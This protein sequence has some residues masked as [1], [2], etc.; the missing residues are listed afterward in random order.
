M[1]QFV[2]GFCNTNNGGKEW[3]DL[4]ADD[5]VLGYSASTPLELNKIL[6]LD[7]SLILDWYTD[8]RL[9][10]NVKKTKIMFAGSKTMLSKFEDFNISREGGQIDFVSSFIY[11]GVI[12]DQKWNWNIHVTSLLRKLGRWLSVLNRILRIL[13]KRTRLAYFN[14]LVFPHL[15]YADTV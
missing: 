4:V 13:D 9:T 6:E 11:L 2:F 15:D 10:L 3:H 5:A 12:L 14:G 8:N 1:E 7:F